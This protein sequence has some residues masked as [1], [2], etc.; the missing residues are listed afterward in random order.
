MLKVMVSLFSFSLIFLLKFNICFFTDDPYYSG[1]RARVP[2]FSKEKQ[3][4]ESQE[5]YVSRKQPRVNRRSIAGSDRHQPTFSSLYQLNQVNDPKSSLYQRL[6]YHGH[7]SHSPRPVLWHAR[8][9]ESGI[10]NW[11]LLVTRWFN[12]AMTLSD[13]LRSSMLNFLLSRFRDRWVNL[14]ANLRASA[15]RHALRSLP[16]HETTINF[17][18]RM[19][20]NNFP[21][22]STKDVN[23]FA[24]LNHKKMKICL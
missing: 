3:R 5:I 19:G 14:P 16:K 6:H 8:S 24:I 11:L 13:S 23:H 4:R 21:K 7:A 9:Y 1:L 18:W 10:G 12:S 17:R 22:F 2:N 20:V 15:P